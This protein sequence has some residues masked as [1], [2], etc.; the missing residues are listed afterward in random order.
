MSSNNPDTFDFR[1]GTAE[2]AGMVSALV[3]RL[4][5][6]FLDDPDGAGAEPFWASVAEPAQAERLAGSNHAYLLA[7]HDNA[8]AGFVGIRDNS[9]VFHLFVDLPYQ[10]QG[11]ARRLWHLAQHKH[12]RDNPG[13]WT[14][15]A[16]PNAVPVYAR[17]G[18]IPEG[19]FQVVHGVRF[20]PMKRV[21]HAYR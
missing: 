10:G 3:K 15:N 18:F 2:D 14:V 19:D 20:L 21:N 8:L 6:E 11:L 16:S 1:P 13:Y 9:H 4:A 5:I 7:F 17:F 12:A